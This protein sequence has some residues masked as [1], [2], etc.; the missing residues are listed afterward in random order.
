[1]AEDRLLGD[2]ITDPELLHFPLACCQ[3]RHQS[4]A[5][6]VVAQE[7]SRSGFALDPAVVTDVRIF[8]DPAQ[9]RLDV[10]RREVRPLRRNLAP[11]RA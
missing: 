7:D 5:V 10:I 3:D 11:E 1:M 6:G 9:D 4:S 2:A 8:A